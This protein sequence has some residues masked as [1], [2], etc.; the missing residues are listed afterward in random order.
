MTIRYGFNWGLFLSVSSMGN[1][2]KKE[3]HKKKENQRNHRRLTEWTE[4]LVTKK[5]K[6][7]KKK[8]T[9]EPRRR[10]STMDRTLMAGNGDGGRRWGPRLSSLMLVETNKQTNKSE[11][12]TAANEGPRSLF[13]CFVFCYLFLFFFRPPLSRP[14][15][16]KSSF[17]DRKI[18]GTWTDLNR[19]FLQI[20]TVFLQLL[21]GLGFNRVVLLVWNVN[22]MLEWP[23]ETLFWIYFDPFWKICSFCNGQL[24]CYWWTKMPNG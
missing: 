23:H 1:L 14:A 18:N 3:N 20:W 22:L 15:T 13:F 4:R 5:K 6:K 12:K 16:P 7:N 10:H 17:W 2:K 9:K 19:W 11:V 21:I 8:K 24:I